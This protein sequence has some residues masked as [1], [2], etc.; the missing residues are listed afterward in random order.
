MKNIK[1]I[2][3]GPSEDEVDAFLSSADAHGA[4]IPGWVRGTELS[5]D[6]KGFVRPLFTARKTNILSFTRYA[7]A[8]AELAKD[9]IGDLVGNGEKAK[10]ILSDLRKSQVILYIVTLEGQGEAS[11]WQ[12]SM[13]K[14]IRAGD[15]GTQEPHSEV[16]P[17]EGA[18]ASGPGRVAEK[19]VASRP[20]LELVPQGT[21]LR[22]A[23]EGTQRAVPL[24]PDAEVRSLRGG[25]RDD[26]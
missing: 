6:G 16:D 25:N 1:V 19:E 17:D 5:N 8:G 14:K 4:C 21:V 20:R 26:G 12:R 11:E 18:E 3:A 10:V 22:Q 23:G 7:I 15:H 2:V 13:E 24:L 9:E